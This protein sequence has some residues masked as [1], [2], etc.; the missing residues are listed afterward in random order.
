[1]LSRVATLGTP[2]DVRSL[3][4]YFYGDAMRTTGRILFI[5]KK[6]FGGGQIPYGKQAELCS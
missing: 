1:M 2:Q 3:A 4:I 5:D 6:K